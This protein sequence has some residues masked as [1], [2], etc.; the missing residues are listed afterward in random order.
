MPGFANDDRLTILN[1][2]RHEV[3]IGRSFFDDYR[4][5]GD[6]G[7]SLDPSGSTLDRLERN[8]RAVQFLPDVT[9]D[10]KFAQLE[11]SECYLNCSAVNTRCRVT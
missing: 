2:A 4:E 5:S 6:A 9:N 10:F 3:Q 7:G 8:T 11:R 1:L